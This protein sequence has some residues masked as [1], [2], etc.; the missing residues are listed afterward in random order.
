MLYIDSFIKYTVH[1]G[2]SAVSSL[3]LSSWFFYKLKKKVWIINILKTIIFLKILLKFFKYIV[4][5]NFPFWF[6]NLEL[7]K[8]FLFKSAANNCGEFSCTRVWVRGLLS[9]FK[10]IQNS[11]SKYT[12][13]KHVIQSFDKEYLLRYWITTRFTWPRGIFL[14]DIIYNYIVSKEAGSITLPVAAMIDTNIKSFLFTFPIPSNDDSINSVCYIISILTKQL[15][16]LKYKKIILWYAHYSRKKKQVSNILFKLNK[17]KM[18]LFLK[19]AQKKLK[20]FVTL[21]YLVKF[22]KNF[23]TVSKGTQIHEILKKKKPK[24]V[25]YFNS[26]LYQKQKFFRQLSVFYCFL[27]KTIKFTRFR[28]TQRYKKLVTNFIKLDKTKLIFRG[29]KR[30]KWKLSVA[31]RFFPLNYYIS[32]ALFKKVHNFYESYITRRIADLA[33]VLQSSR[34]FKRRYQYNINKYNRYH[35]FYK[36]PVSKYW[37]L[38]YIRKYSIKRSKRRWFHSVFYN[39]GVNEFYTYIH[40]KKK[41][42]PSLS[43]QYY[44]NWFFF[45]FNKLKKFKFIKKIKKLKRIKKVKRINWLNKI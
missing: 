30:N 32:F 16:L 15:L 20:K 25:I 8:E 17:I 11:I 42:I 39:K 38:P 45:L 36:H 3:V 13:K 9:N 14:S 2:H 18:R 34:W 28:I 23:K 10:K 29:R 27:K 22:Q 5:Y 41:K 6:I 19:L 44:N 7:T 24:S 1:I 33:I 40:W 26:W 43:L 35:R 21:D 4:N 37:L 12:F 31:T